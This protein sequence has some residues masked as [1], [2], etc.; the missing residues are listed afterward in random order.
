MIADGWKILL[1]HLFNCS[2]SRGILNRFESPLVNV[3]VVVSHECPILSTFTHI[4]RDFSCLPPY[5]L[6][7]MLV[8]GVCGCIVVFELL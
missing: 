3:S 7:L 4:S 2:I 6:V 1:G 8:E 5:C